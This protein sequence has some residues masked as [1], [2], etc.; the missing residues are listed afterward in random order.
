MTDKK[1]P[2]EAE[3][4]VETEASAETA[5]EAQPRELTDDELKALCRERICPGCDIGAEAEDIRLR[6]LAELENT[7]RRLEK[8]KEDFRKYATEKVLGDLLPVLDN[9]DLALMHTP[10]SDACKNFVMGVEMTRKAFLDV[11]SSNGLIPVG[12]ANEEFTPERHEA[13]G[14]DPRDDMDEGI[15]TQVMQRGYLL[16]GRLLRPAKVMVSTKPQ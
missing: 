3:E 5:A 1:K 12:E 6:A 16:N 15:V 11:L 2:T 7:R 4:A 9:L 14:Q 10:E 13:V 8:D